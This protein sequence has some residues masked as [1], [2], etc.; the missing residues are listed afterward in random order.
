MRLFIVFIF[1]LVGAFAQDDFAKSVTLKTN[2]WTQGRFDNIN[3]YNDGFGPLFVYLQGNQYFSMACAGILVAVIFAFAGHYAIVGPKHF[4]HNHGKIYAF[5]RI[6]R[7]VHFI[8]AVSWVILVPTGIVMMFGYAFG[9][10]FFVRLCKNMHFFSTIAFAISLVPM[11]L[12]WFVRM[13][14]AL[15]DIKWMLIIGGYLSKHK[16]PIPAGKFNAG[17]K[18]WFW[19]A[20]LGGFVMIL[21]GLSMFFLDYNVPGLKEATN[22]SQIEILRISALIHNILGIVCATF[23][24]VHVYMAVF[25]IKGAIHSIISGYKEEEE[26]YILHHYWYQELVKKGIIQPSVFEKS[27]TNLK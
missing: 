1:A 12:F 13:L 10:G 18:A 5:S 22:L 27:Y 2:M 8:A 16:R 7:L 23:L 21:T 25:A 11:F 20:T 3:V 17:Q 26:V 4:S 19:V 15:Y 14:P 6:E 9:G 24:L